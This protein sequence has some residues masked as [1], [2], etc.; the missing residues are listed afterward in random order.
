MMNE[1]GKEYSQK[2]ATAHFLAPVA[3]SCHTDSPAWFISPFV[4]IIKVGQL[5]FGLRLQI[6]TF[7]DIFAYVGYDEFVPNNWLINTVMRSI[8]QG[9]FAQRV[10]C[11]NIPFFFGGFNRYYSKLSS[12]HHIR[13][14]CILLIRAQLNNTIIPKVLRHFPSGTSTKTV[15]HFIQQMRSGKFAKYDYG[16]SARNQKI[17]VQ[18]HPPEYDLSKVDVPI[19]T[20][21]GQNDWLTNEKVS[22][23]LSQCK[24]KSVTLIF[25]LGLQTTC[26]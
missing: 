4:N 12:T 2:I 5:I 18:C 26:I 21:W 19:A 7:Q 10:F 9:R 11:R 6:N 17:Y 15:T 16:T 8:C 23:F 22:I 20:Y 1:R 3:Y 13:P 25:Y 14:K 24:L